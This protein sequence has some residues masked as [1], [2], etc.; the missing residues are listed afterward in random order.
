M[1]SNLIQSQSKL[2]ESTAE[3]SKWPLMPA[4]E[5]LLQLL[6]YWH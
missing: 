4:N 3:L 5:T 1:V 2:Y 6:D